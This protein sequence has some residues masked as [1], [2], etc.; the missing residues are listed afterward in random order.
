MEYMNGLRGKLK[1]F[2]T[3]LEKTNFFFLICKEHYIEMEN[4][5]E[6]N[7]SDHLEFNNPVSLILRSV[8]LM[9]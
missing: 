8:L 1:L 5:G 6:Y 2:K 7:F 9:Y 3:S 4:S